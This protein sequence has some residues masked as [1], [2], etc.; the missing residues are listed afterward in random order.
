VVLTAGTLVN[1]VRL[2]HR[3]S[4]LTRLDAQP[5]QQD[6]DYL[7]VQAPGVEVDDVTR[8]AAA[9]HAQAEELDVLDLV[10][11]NLPLPDAVDLARAVDTVAFRS[12]GFAVGRGALHAV[13]VRRD[14]WDRMEASPEAGAPR[15]RDRAD[16]V[17]LM[18]RLKQ[19]AARATDFVVVPSLRAVDA[20]LP[21]RLGVLQAT[22]D[23][24]APA[25]LAIPAAR[26]SLVLAGL[27]LSP[28][29]GAAAA[30]TVV[31]QPYLVTPGTASPVV[32]AS[33]H[34]QP[35]PR[36]LHHDQGGRSL[37]PAPESE[38]GRG[39]RGRSH[40]GHRSHR[41]PPARL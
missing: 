31:L 30:A 25:A 16:L 11:G 23:A 18:V 6:E 41:G 1:G 7:L 19:H 27:V 12:A 37:E 13:L 8:R 22:Y 9:A 32:A 36:P 24:F 20:G 39:R 40:R 5:G 4:G 15:V 29:W 2:R 3:L 10:P 38:R 28:G 17:R 21:E 14:V 33:R 26:S 34:R 35:R